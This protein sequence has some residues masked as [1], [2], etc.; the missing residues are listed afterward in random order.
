MITYVVYYS[1][2]CAIF[3]WTFHNDYRSL[4]RCEHVCVDT[5]HEVSHMASRVIY[6]ITQ[7]SIYIHTCLNN[8]SE[9]LR[10]IKE[11]RGMLHEL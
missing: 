3:C 5:F 7:L 2:K 4:F 9:K 10:E 6:V 1:M 11:I 8:I